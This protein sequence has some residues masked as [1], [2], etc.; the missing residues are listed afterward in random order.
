MHEPHLWKWRYDRLDI[1]PALNSLQRIFIIVN[2]ILFHRGFLKI[3]IDCRDPTPIRSTIIKSSK[4]VFDGQCFNIWFLFLG[5]GVPVRAVT[6]RGQ[7]EA[8]P[9]APQFRNGCRRC[10]RP[11]ALQIMNSRQAGTPSG[12][13]PGR[14][15]PDKCAFNW[16]DLQSP[17]LFIQLFCKPHLDPSNP[18]SPP[19]SCGNQFP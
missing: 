3:H 4:S 17:C 13:L 2:L 7:V 16:K 9:D 14:P 6:I 10:V 12:T 1:F 19:H 15:G 11:P 8:T 18:F 5:I